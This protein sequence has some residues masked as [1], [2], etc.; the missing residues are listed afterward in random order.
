MSS[1]SGTYIASLKIDAQRE[2]ERTGSLSEEMKIE[3]KFRDLD[4]KIVGSKI[5]YSN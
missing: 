1:I 2:L 4:F 5:Y 3:L